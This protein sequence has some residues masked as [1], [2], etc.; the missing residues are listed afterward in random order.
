MDDPYEEEFSEEEY[1]KDSEEESDYDDLIIVKI[2]KRR[3]REVCLIDTWVGLSGR[4]L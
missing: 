4:K 3:T 2:E 1:E